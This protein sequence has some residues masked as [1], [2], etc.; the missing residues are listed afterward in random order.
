[1]LKKYPFLIGV[2]DH[3]MLGSMFELVKGAR[4]GK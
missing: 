4:N 2:N 1:M 3:F